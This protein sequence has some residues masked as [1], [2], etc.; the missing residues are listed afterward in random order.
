MA[1]L[2]STCRAASKGLE[3]VMALEPGAEEV[4]RALNVRGKINLA[5]L[6]VTS[7]LWG[8]CVSRFP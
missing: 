4:M 3:E 8:I 1:P 2:V 6:Q 5:F 7:S